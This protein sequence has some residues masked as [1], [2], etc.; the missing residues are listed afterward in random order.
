MLPV[1][2]GH[3]Q[4]ADTRLMRGCCISACTSLVVL[5]PFPV[6]H[7]PDMAFLNI[8]MGY[9]Y[10]FPNKERDRAKAL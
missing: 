2:M 9:G 3:V 10:G 8:I 1:K 6:P 7:I 5:F 4:D